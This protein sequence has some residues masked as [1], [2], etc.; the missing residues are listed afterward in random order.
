M[1]KCPGRS[2]TGGSIKLS[3]RVTP[4]APCQ[5]IFSPYACYQDISNFGV[6]YTRFCYCSLGCP[7]ISNDTATRLHTCGDPVV[8]ELERER[9][10]RMYI[11]HVPSTLMQ[12]RHARSVS[13]HAFNF[14]FTDSLNCS[15]ID[16]FQTYTSVTFSEPINIENLPILKLDQGPRS[17]LPPN[18]HR[19]T[20]QT[21]FYL[22][23]ILCYLQVLK[24]AVCSG[25]V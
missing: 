4:V 1:E 13:F 17:S 14:H 7:V 6:Y 15:C 19:H 21:I 8:Q 24:D 10:P 16:I 12:T 11:E 3:A 9:L 20:N 5:G 23:R 18:K 2:L 22:Y 25:T